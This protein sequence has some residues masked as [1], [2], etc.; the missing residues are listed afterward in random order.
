MPLSAKKRSIAPRVPEPVSRTRKGSEASSLDRHFLLAGERMVGR[1][2]HHQRVVHEAGGF[3]VKAFRHLPHD[4]KVDAVGCQQTQHRFAVGDIEMYRHLGVLAAKVGQDVG[5]DRAH[6]GGHRDV[7]LA[8]IHAAQL[9]QIGLQVVEPGG[10]ALAGVQHLA[11]GLGQKDFL[12]E[13][14]GQRQA[15]GFS[16]CPAPASRRRAATG[17]VPR[18]PAKTTDGGRPP[19]IPG[20]GGASGGA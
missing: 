5:G 13:L 1:R 6:G 2:D 9:R 18:P 19:Q 11:S 12:A 10:N 20:I 4:G 7:E 3:Q 15:R 17:A 14:L 8:A 16:R